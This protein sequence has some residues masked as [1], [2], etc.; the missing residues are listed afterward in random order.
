LLISRIKNQKKNQ[1]GYLSYNLKDDRTETN[2]LSLS[3]PE[4]A[5]ELE[6]LWEN[7]A[8]ENHVYPLDGRGW[9]EKIAADVTKLETNN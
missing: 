7:W 2:N 9:N 3:N 1:F 5:K 8:S 4:K 6:M